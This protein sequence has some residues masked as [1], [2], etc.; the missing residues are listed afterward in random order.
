MDTPRRWHGQLR[1]FIQWDLRFALSSSQGCKH[2]VSFAIA[3]TRQIIPLGQHWYTYINSVYERW[4]LVVSEGIWVFEG[5][6]DNYITADHPCLN[7]IL[8]NVYILLGFPDKVYFQTAWQEIRFL[9]MCHEVIL[10]SVISLL[11]LPDVL[12]QFRVISYFQGNSFSS[13]S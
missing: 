6:R 11:R 3:T 1:I 9:A 4:A 10:F 5:K 13:T 8:A 12:V 7:R 2:E